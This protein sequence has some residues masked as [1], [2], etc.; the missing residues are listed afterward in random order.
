MD[1]IT[2]FILILWAFNIGFGAALLAKKIEKYSEK[3]DDINS[4]FD[5]M[6][7]SWRMP[8]LSELDKEHR[9]GEAS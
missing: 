9:D 1:P 8:E 7:L 3:L 6:D 4:A 5:S 2:A